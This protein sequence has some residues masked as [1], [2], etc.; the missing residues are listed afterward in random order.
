MEVKFDLDVEARDTARKLG[1]G[2]ERALSPGTHPAFV[3]MVT[4]LVRE[5]TE[6][7][8]PRRL[9]PLPRCTDCSCPA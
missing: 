8:E 7:A 3:S 5:Y 2:Y 9:S 4:D 1:I 6:R